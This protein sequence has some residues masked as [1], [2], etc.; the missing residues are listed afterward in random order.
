MDNNIP[1]AFLLRTSDAQELI[2]TALGY[3]IPTFLPILMVVLHR[4]STT[5]QLATGETTLGETTP[6]RLTVLQYQLTTKMMKYS[7]VMIAFGVLSSGVMYSAIIAYSWAANSV[8]TDGRVSFDMYIGT[9]MVYIGMQVL[10]ILFVA[11]M[12]HGGDSTFLLFVYLFDFAAAAT[13]AVLTGVSLFEFHHKPAALTFAWIIFMVHAVRMLLMI[14]WAVWYYYNHQQILNAASRA[15]A[16]SVTGGSL[17]SKGGKGG[18]QLDDGDGGE[19]ADEDADAVDFEEEAKQD[20]Y[21]P[22]YGN[23][24]MGNTHKRNLD[25]N[26]KGQC[27]KA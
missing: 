25:R 15:Q 24:R 22:E 21:A 18:K 1:A 3:F 12:F 27:T 19:D 26:Q 6:G 9:S 4:F 7:G 2:D 8:I 13:L 14:V 5:T 23:I 11:M 16:N 10:E 17:A 20:V